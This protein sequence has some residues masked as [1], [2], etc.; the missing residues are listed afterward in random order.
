MNALRDEELALLDD[1]A[2][3][4]ESMD[5]HSVRIIQHEESKRMLIV[6][7]NATSAA[8]LSVRV[9]ILESLDEV[10]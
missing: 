6:R 9:R 5:N 4:R 1:L 7:L 10:K 8:L 3:I 2:A